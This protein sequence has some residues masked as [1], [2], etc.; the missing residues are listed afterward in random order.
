MKKQTRKN[1]LTV[2]TTFV[3]VL[4]IAFSSMAF[5]LVGDWE[6]T[7]ESGVDF[8][9]YRSSDGFIV[10]DEWIYDDPDHDQ[11][12]D[13]TGYML[14]ENYSIDGYWLNEDGSRDT[15]VKRREE[16]TGSLKTL[17]TAKSYK[18]KDDTGYSLSIK[19]KY[20]FMTKNNAIGKVTLDITYADGS[21]VNNWFYLLPQNTTDRKSYRAYSLR[22]GDSF[23]ESDAVFY[24]TVSDDQETVLFTSR[25][26]TTPLTYNLK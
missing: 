14:K 8:Y 3:L 22:K 17:K 12:T 9:R 5:T 11:Y 10:K 18:Y 7:T 24:L 19:A 23:L 21:E 15:T 25:G 4:S 16:N 26:Y 2:I 13:P 20:F 6:K 1:V